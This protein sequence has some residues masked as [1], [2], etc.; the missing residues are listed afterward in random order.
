MLLLGSA[1]AQAPS[2]GFGPAVTISVSG[3]PRTV[4]A[5]DYVRNITT[6]YPIYNVTSA[7]GVEGIAVWTSGSTLNAVTYDTGIG[8]WKNT[9]INGFSGLNF[10]VNKRTV[11][12]ISNAGVA[13]SM[14]YDPYS[15]TWKTMTFAISVTNIYRSGGMVA[16]YNSTLQQIAIAQ[17]DPTTGNFQVLTDYTGP[18]TLI[19]I[20]QDFMSWMGTNGV[21]RCAYYDRGTHQWKPK[22]FA[23]YIYD[24][25]AK[26]GIIAGV[27]PYDTILVS[28]FDIEEG[29]WVDSSF[30]GKSM[31]YATNV[32]AGTIYY[33]D[34]SGI[35]HIGYDH[36][37]NRFVKGQLTAPYCK[38][39]F[40]QPEPNSTSILYLSCQV[41][42]AAF[43][44]YECGDGHTVTIANTYKQYLSPNYYL[45]NMFTNQSAPSLGC[46]EYVP[47]IDPLHSTDANETQA[48]LFPN[49]CE[50]GA[51]VH[52]TSKAQLQSI[53]IL[54][55]LGQTVYQDLVHGSAIDFRLPQDLAKGI[56]IA[57]IQLQR[58][59]VWREKVIVY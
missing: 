6:T 39:Y 41:V 52:L 3:N 28:A 2:W 8:E 33:E 1:F 40:W 13:G 23:G 46:G 19:N 48:Q 55:E 32:L 38:N 47:M 20:E 45:V 53:R 31:E 25:D 5:F 29:I 34:S 14:V 57:E 11:S 54:N 12:W 15:H 56:Y 58:G 17:Y 27:T 51:M 26:N 10:I 36:V 30:G 7:S 35:H 37:A 16:A 43:D 21:F 50:A 22:Q 49:P 24:A 44:H 4:Q 59:K 9:T 18:N 42:G